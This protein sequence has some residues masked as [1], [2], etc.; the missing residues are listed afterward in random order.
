MSDITVE[1]VRHV[2]KLACLALT[3]EEELRYTEQLG[4]ILDYVRQLSELDT[5]GQEPTSH[6]IPIANVLRPDIPRPGLE[7][8]DL[9]AAAPQAE[10]G[11]F[12]V[13]KIL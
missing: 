4:K 8:A 9:L 10:Q 3:A 1:T 6:A 5:S 12:R 7:R 11:M 13:P 2:A